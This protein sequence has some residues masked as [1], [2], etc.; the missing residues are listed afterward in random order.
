MCGKGEGDEKWVLLSSRF[1]IVDIGSTKSKLGKLYLS[2]FSRVFW[3][4]VEF[5]EIFQKPPGRPFKAP[6]N[7]YLLICIY[8]FL[9][10]TTLR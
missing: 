3:N 8:G 10:E 1:T 6:C 2:F 5:L 9:M 4:W 7:T